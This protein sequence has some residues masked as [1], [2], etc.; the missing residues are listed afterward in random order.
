VPVHLYRKPY[1]CPKIHFEEKGPTVEGLLT[2]SQMV[3]QVKHGCGDES[4]ESGEF[5]A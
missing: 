5:T 2:R 4:V 3:Q 1:L